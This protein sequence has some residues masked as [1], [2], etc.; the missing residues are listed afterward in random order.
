MKAASGTSRASNSTMLARA[1]ALNRAV[2]A[3]VRGVSPHLLAAPRASPAPRRFA[4]VI[5]AVATPEAPQKKA[6][7][8]QAASFAS[9][10]VSAGIPYAKM[11]VGELQG[12]PQAASWLGAVLLRLR[13]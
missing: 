8:A 2:P 13:R 1:A 11:T 9:A 4:S 5:T 10:A 7:D 6:A 3:L 12:G